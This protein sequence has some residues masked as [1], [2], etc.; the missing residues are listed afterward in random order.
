MNLNIAVLSGDGIGPEI[1]EQAKKTILAIGKKFN[2]NI[3]F[4]TG[5]VGAIA[6]DKTGNPLPPETLEL[7]TFW[8]HR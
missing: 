6:I 5:L 3:T 4:K 7:G 1:I 8:C 2:H